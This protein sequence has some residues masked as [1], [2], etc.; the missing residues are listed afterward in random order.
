MQERHQFERDWKC[1]ISVDTFYIL[2]YG[3]RRR[4]RAILQ[5][6]FNKKK[7]VGNWKI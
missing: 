4:G 5:I 1:E 3:K 7:T 6:L 2:S